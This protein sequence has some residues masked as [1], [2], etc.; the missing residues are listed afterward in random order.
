MS[1]NLPVSDVNKSFSLILLTC[2]ALT[3]LV[4]ISETCQDQT[5]M[6]SLE[7]GNENWLR[8]GANL[9][10]FLE[11]WKLQSREFY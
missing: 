11:K 7:T 6:L 3:W 5:N 9:L 1:F 2:K 10:W 4:D 8:I